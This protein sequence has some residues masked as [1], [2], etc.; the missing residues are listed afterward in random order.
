MTVLASLTAF[1]LIFY[2][3]FLLILKKGWDIAWSTDPQPGENFQQISVIIPVRNEHD[4][5]GKLLEQLRSLSYPKFEVI[6][7]DDHSSDKT[8]SLVE[9]VTSVDGRFR[10][11]KNDGTGKKQALTTG[12]RNAKGSLIV[13]TDGDCEVQRSWLT[14]I[15]QHFQ[16]VN[17]KM[18]F[19][20]VSIQGTTFFGHLQAIEFS[21]LI[22]SGVS[23]WALGK[24]VMCNG[25]NLA[26]QKETFDE[27]N[28]YEGNEHI[29][30]GDDEFLMRKIHARYPSGV[31]FLNDEDGNVLTE[32][33]PD[34][35]TFIR[36]RL[37]WAG[38]WR[39]NQSLTSKITALFVLMIQ[40]AMIAAFSI[41]VIFPDPST[42]TLI[43]ILL[44]MRFA[45]EAWFLISVCRFLKVEWRWDAFLLLQFIYPFYIVGIGLFSNLTAV[46]WKDRRI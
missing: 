28:G 42:V 13:T 17:T 40:L 25:A 30:S 21:S 9:I 8:A 18:V 2:L 20:G 3:F 1:I 33:A 32:S 46:T 10:L 15:N 7:V 43:A 4:A 16:D 45:T 12:I 37:R 39:H 35:K 26:F 34:V 24:P 38:K 44:L 19:G 31:M 5:I 6:V 27:V 41:L 22:G 14:R 23:L 11:I 36:Q 29:A